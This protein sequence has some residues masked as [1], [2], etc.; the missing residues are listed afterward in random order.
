MVSRKA[1]ATLLSMVVAVLAFAAA[2][3]AAE[4]RRVALIIGN[5][6]Y[7]ALPKL[8][9]AAK[10]ARDLNAALRRLGW[11]TILKV[12]VGRRDMV[13][14]VADFTGQIATGASGLVFYAGHGIESAGQNFLIPVDAEL[15]T[16]ADLVS[17]AV[18]L[19]DV[20]A[21]L[22]E[23]RNPLNVVI[24]DACRDNPLTRRG[25]SAE[26]GLGIV[27]LA[28]S[29][30]F[31]AYSA[32]PGQ[33]AQDGA[34]G[35]NGVFTGELLR[36]LQRPGLKIE[37][38][39][40]VVSQGVR[41]KTGGRQN[42]WI[43]A[44]LQG[45]F[46]MGAQQ[47]PAEPAAA[48]V[49]P[50]TDREGMF[51]SSIQSSSYVADFEEYLRLFP[52]G[53]FAGL[54]RN[55]ISALSAA[56]KAPPPKEEPA[57]QQVASLSVPPLEPIDREY[58]VSQA[59]RI[60]E[61][62]N[63]TAKQVGQLREGTKVVVL[64]K[65]RNENWYLLE[66]GGKPAGYVPTTA[67]EDP[68]VYA[69]RTRKESEERRIKAEQDRKIAEERAQQLAAL[70][71][72]R[73]KLEAERRQQEQAARAVE[74][75]RRQAEEQERQ[76]REAEQQRIVDEQ[77]RREEEQR[78][79]EEEEKRIVEEKIK[80]QLAMVIVK[81]PPGAQRATPAVGVYVPP[82]PGTVFKDCADVCPEMISIQTG[83]YQMGASR[84]DRDA[85]SAE[86]PPQIVTLSEPFAIGAYEITRAQFG[87]FVGETKHNPTGCTTL[88]YNIVTGLNF[89]FDATRRWDNVG[90]DQTDKHP[91]ACVSFDDARAYVRWLSEK[92][93][94]N[95]RLPSEAEW[96][97]VARSGSV[98]TRP[99][100]EN[101]NDSCHYS[102]NGDMTL[103]TLSTL[104]LWPVHNC[105]DGHAYTAPVGSFPPNGMGAYDMMGN[106]WEWTEDCWTNTL[107][108]IAIDGRP[109]TGGDCSFRAVRGGA[110]FSTKSETFRTSARV[111]EPTNR[112]APYIGIRV[113]R[114]F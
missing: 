100:G 103:N 73:Q 34:P 28:P 48:A 60:R 57:Q 40:K 70:D 25:R 107:A 84:D 83:R 3:N 97:Y 53:T 39:F 69:E 99:W 9:N 43:Q 41:E 111:A 86:R 47:A 55:K 13:R 52:N 42:P 1:I 61:V 102:N 17:E 44:S 14:A 36:A 38:T 76:R 81:A 87:A 74:E 18:R 59:A 5:D 54:A 37:D 71:A 106:V 50:A 80:R 105:R 2:P 95:Y 35:A 67:L 62:P 49:A 93:G 31:V 11:Q 114:K 91:V 45:D 77:R 113:A 27:S 108:G 7:K 89:G 22:E 101:P 51:W 68:S 12:D 112:R 58:V 24:L 46:Y 98:G 63:V 75:A 110:W 21:R 29:G 90:F 16:E 85:T 96:E 65:V 64:G 8:N 92:T 109:R 66:Q 4:D 15:E 30:L 26:R 94:W 6:A 78:R 56:A 88:S 10:D 20:M 23:A 104:S 32:A 79:R 19:N 72:Q 33:K 82:A